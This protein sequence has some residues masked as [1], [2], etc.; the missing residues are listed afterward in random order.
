MNATKNLLL[1]EVPPAASLAAVSSVLDRIGNTPLLRLER[2]SRE[3]PD[4][5]FYAKAEWLNPGGAVK[6]REAFNMIREGELIGEIRSGKTM[7]DS[8]S[9]NT[10]MAD[11]MIASVN[12]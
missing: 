5:E 1:P 11:A 12:G 2:V 3:F 10:G 8:T 6:D 9:G 4:V 7:L